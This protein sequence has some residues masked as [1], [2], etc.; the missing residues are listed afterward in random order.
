MHRSTRH[1]RS[2]SA[3]RYRCIVAFV[4][5]FASFAVLSADAADSAPASTHLVAAIPEHFPPIF[6]VTA[7]GVPTGFG[8]EAMELVAALAGLK[9][10]YRVYQDWDHVYAALRSGAADLVPNMGITE[11][12]RHE[13]AFSRPFSQF[14]LRLF[15]RE[16]DSDHLRTLDDLAHHRGPVAVVEGNAGL[17]LLARRRDIDMRTYRSLP[18]AFVALRTGE[19]DA[20]LFPAEAA[21]YLRRELE[22]ESR[23]EAVGPPLQEIPRAVAVRKDR[24]E[25]LERI[26]RALAHVLTTPEF[27]L[28]R[29]RWFPRPEPWW[30]WRH[31]LIL[32]TGLALAAGAAAA[33]MRYIGLRRTNSRLRR[34]LALNQA[35]LDTTLEAILTVDAEGIVHSANPSAVRMLQS[36]AT[37]LIGSSI[38]SVLGPPGGQPACAEQ[39][40]SDFYSRLVAVSDNSRDGIEIN[41]RRGQE[42][43]PVRTRVARLRHFRPPLLVLTL[44]DVSA[45]RQAEDYAQFLTDHDPLTGLLNQ[46]G[47]LLI[48]EN[49]LERAARAKSSVCCVMLGLDRF[50]HFNEVYG[51]T[52]GDTLLTEVASYLNSTVR[53]GD[54]V[55]RQPESLLARAGGDRF[56]IM[57]A[58]ADSAGGHR[59]CER[60]L[61]G[62]GNISVATP[63]GSARC[64]AH[65]GI[66]CYPLHGASPAELISHAEVALLVAREDRVHRVAEFTQDMRSAHHEDDRRV[67]MLFD[68]LEQDRFVLHFQPVQSLRDGS[69]SH[70]EALVRIDPGDGGRLVMPGEFISAAERYGMIARIDYAVLRRVF[71][72]LAGTHADDAFSLAANISAAHFGD[73]DLLAWLE[74]LFAENIVQP[75]QLVFEI[76]ETAALHNIAMARDFMEPLHALGCRFALDDFGVGFSSFEYLRLLPVDYVK[77]DGSFIRNLP[78]NPEDQ[79]ITRAITEVAHATGRRVIAEF[80][81]SQVHVDLLTGM[82]VDYAQGYHIGRPAAD[83]PHVRPAKRSI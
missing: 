82:G 59:A 60:I 14:T 56:L 64:D 43:F 80:V 75:R 67:Q 69:V 35:I 19:V 23:V 39:G 57:L 61:Q 32:L 79:A 27:A 76:T 48:L 51:R 25:L 29:Q 77:I 22:I 66:A 71:S 74:K 26:D 45:Q 50:A 1:L 33:A 55:G 46:Q 2:P 7:N 42:S 11:D 4:T 16:E 49:M 34:S 68:A 44:Q 20:L 78:D 8:V 18:D 10:E 37:K 15:V 53:Q 65:A 40:F 3:L 62:L 36:P 12:R 24:G 17:T 31:T 21:E 73:R 5:L 28:L 6:D 52:A 47:A 70:Y 38:C 58:D 30:T 54:V 81:E 41:A 72:H 63:T 13:F 9:I 83:P